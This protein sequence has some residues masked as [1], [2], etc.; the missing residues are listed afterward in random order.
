MTVT[1]KADN[2]NDTTSIFQDYF[3]SF[4]SK[5]KEVK[6]QQDSLEILTMQPNAKKQ[7]EEVKI[8]IASGIRIL[9]DYILKMQRAIELITEKTGDFDVTDLEDS[10]EKCE[11]MIAIV[12][13]KQDT[14][15][16]KKG[17]EPER[18]SGN[19]YGLTRD[20]QRILDNWEEQMKEIVG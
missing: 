20:E 17:V 1:W 9:Q 10:K 8:E 15:V 3:K 6:D 4:K 19:R 2:R 13:K 11:K 18:P 14:V 12:A 7:L 16:S 5:F